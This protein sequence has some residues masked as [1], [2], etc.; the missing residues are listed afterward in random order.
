MKKLRFNVT[1]LAWESLGY[2][3]RSLSPGIQ[4]PATIFEEEDPSSNMTVI[5][6]EVASLAVGFYLILNR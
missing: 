2:A 3:S 4:R 5:L 6:K 1:R